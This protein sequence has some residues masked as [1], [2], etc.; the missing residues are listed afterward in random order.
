MK[1]IINRVN[2]MFL[3]A[4]TVIGL[5]IPAIGTAQPSCSEESMQMGQCD[6]VG[7]WS[8]IPCCEYTITYWCFTVAGVEFCAPYVWVCSRRSYGCS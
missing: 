7:N 2:H 4:L 1:R 6:L 3:L 8:D 5:M